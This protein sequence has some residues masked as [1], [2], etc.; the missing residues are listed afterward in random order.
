LGALGESRGAAMRATQTAEDPFDAWYN[1]AVVCGG[2]NDASCVEPSLRQAIAADPMWFKPHWAL[3][4]VLML[5]GRINEAQAEAARAAELDAGK[6]AE[7]GRTL[8][9]I[10]ATVS[11]ADHLQK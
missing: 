8:Q 4:Q 5:T 6:D 7:V 11:R 9:Q 10:R 3:A 1:L 2:Q